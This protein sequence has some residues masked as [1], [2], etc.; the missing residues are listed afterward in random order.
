MS[1]IARVWTAVVL[2]ALAGCGAATVALDDAPSDDKRPSAAIG[3][4]APS[5]SAGLASLRSAS[6]SRDSTA[7]ALRRRRSQ[8]ALTSLDGKA[9][10]GVARRTLP[11]LVS[12]EGFRAR[13]PQKD[14]RLVRI[15]GTYESQVVTDEGEKLLAQSTTPL[16]AR[17]PD[18]SFAPVDMTLKRT[19]TGDF[20]PR[21]AAA[22]VTLGQTADRGA[23]LAGA[24]VTIAP[25]DARAVS[26]VP[27]AGSVF[28]PNIY[29]TQKD[30]DFI[31]TPSEAGG[32]QVQWVLA[33]AAR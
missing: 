20:A 25:A 30:T 18:G 1:R 11:D 7:S 3:A 24:K 6:N 29:G 16:R 21:N 12:R 14:M 13:R 31:S 32:A 33:L 23:R 26:G 2:L 9:A 4:G 5:S 27:S 28:Y 22:P 17:R 19:A 10:L 15:I 8:T